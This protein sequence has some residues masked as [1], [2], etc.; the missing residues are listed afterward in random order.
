MR[1]CSTAPHTGNRWV[2]EKNQVGDAGSSRQVCRTFFPS[3][4]VEQCRRRKV[5]TGKNVVG[6]SFSGFGD[7]VIVS[8]LVISCNFSSL[9]KSSVPQFVFIIFY[10]LSLKWFSQQYRLRVHS[11]AGPAGLPSRAQHGSLTGRP[12]PQCACP[13]PHCRP[14]SGHGR[15]CC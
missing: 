14:R 8:K 3:A 7:A 15:G 4:D 2:V 9:N 6:V 12:S 13:A 11:L 1:T 5:I 10:S